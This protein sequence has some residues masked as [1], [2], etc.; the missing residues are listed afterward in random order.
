MKRIWQS[1]KLKRNWSYDPAILPLGIY[2]QEL[3]KTQ[4]QIII[5]QMY[6][7]ALFTTPKGRTKYHQKINGQINMV[8]THNGMV[9]SH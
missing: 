5:Y 3:E 1:Q 7:A 2:P 6:M 4:N 9:F 8:Y